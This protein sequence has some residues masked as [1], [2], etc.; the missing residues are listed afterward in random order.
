MFKNIFLGYTLLSAS[1]ISFAFADTRGTPESIPWEKGLD[2]ALTKAKATG[3][4]I[5]L[6]FFMVG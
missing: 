3:K 6:D 1:F 5:L 4:P 2:E